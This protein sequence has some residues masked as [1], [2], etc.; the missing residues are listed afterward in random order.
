MR[1]KPSVIRDQG[2][3]VR[4]RYDGLGRRIEKNVDVK[5]TRY[6]YD[7]EDIILEYDGEGN[8]IAE[9][10]HGPGIDE[11]L[12][13]ERDGEIYYFIADA[14]GSIKALV[15]GEGGVRQMYEY[16][17]FGRIR[18]L[19]EEGAPIPIEDAIPNP[20]TFTGREFD[21]ETGLYYY[22]ARYYGP[23]LGRFLQE[24]PILYLQIEQELKIGSK[25]YGG[26][27]NTIFNRP[28]E[29][30]LKEPQILN[31]YPYCQ[32]NPVNYVDPIGL[33]RCS[34]L[35]QDIRDG[36][37]IILPIGGAACFAV[38]GVGC[39]GATAGTLVIPCLAKC[40][41]ICAT[42]TVGGMVVCDL[43]ATYIEGICREAEEKMRRAR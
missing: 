14:L 5:I 24:D 25:S 34:E 35:A 23:S 29:I 2:S 11:P 30:F 4:Y 8:L 9:Y 40:F 3:V 32:N 36:C 6:V 39:T 17:A 22:R 33:D 12:M 43:I 18:V 13:M 37:A 7:N 16:D 26:D 27:F 41:S 10:L 20:Y 28:L 19:D 38:C 31:F 42:V 1:I 15:D 21:P